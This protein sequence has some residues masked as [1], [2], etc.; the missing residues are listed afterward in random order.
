M[1]KKGCFWL[2]FL[3]VS[4]LQAQ[5]QYSGW[6]ASINTFGLSKQFSVHFDAQ[7]RTTDKFE[8]IQTVIL[9][10]GI[11]YHL[12]K[13][14]SATLGYAYIPNRRTVAAVTGYLAEHRI[15]QQALYNQ[16][17]KTVSVSHRL[18]FEQRFL[19]KPVLAGND[20]EADG[21][22]KAYRFRYFIRNVVPLLKSVSF[23]KGPFFALQNEVFINTGNK[24]WVNGKAFDQNRLYAAFG[25]RLPH[26]ID[27]ELGYMNQYI[28]TRTAFVN[29]HIAQVAIY[30]RL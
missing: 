27:L 16:K 26:K 25:Y 14:A 2:F 20:L 23:A 13:K 19:P 15:W 12:N 5:V 4:V 18:R 21:F 29:N 22:S 24:K 10:P 11:N 9:R 3:Y 6:G 7:A 28:S 17:W 8:N 30:K 1:K